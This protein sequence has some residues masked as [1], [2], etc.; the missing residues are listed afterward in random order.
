[1]SP[2][3]KPSTENVVSCAEA[4]ADGAV[5][6]KLQPCPSGVKENE[7]VRM[8]VDS[9]DKTEGSSAPVGKASAKPNN[10]LAKQQSGKAPVKTTTQIYD[11]PEIEYEDCPEEF[12][13]MLDMMLELALEEEG[14]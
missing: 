11:G 10:P 6:L 14:Y 4:E 13:W 3:R 8:E 5:E 9:E 7:T 2:S 1:M 12:K